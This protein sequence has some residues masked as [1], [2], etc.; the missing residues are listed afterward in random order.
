MLYPFFFFFVLLLCLQHWSA[1][2]QTIHFIHFKCQGVFVSHM[3]SQFAG[4]P[5]KLSPQSCCIIWSAVFPHVTLL[6]DQ[7]RHS[8]YAPRRLLNYS[9][10]PPS[11]H[12]PSVV[13]LGRIRGQLTFTRHIWEWRQVVWLVGWW[14]VVEGRGGCRGLKW[15]EWQM[16]REM[17]KK[18]GRKVL[19]MYVCVCWPAYPSPFVSLCGAVVSAGG[20]HVKSRTL[21]SRMA[22]LPGFSQSE[23]PP[24]PPSLSFTPSSWPA[25]KN[26]Y[27]LC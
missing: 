4:T 6:C 10:A 9:K 26:T 16:K 2:E 15:R 7:D 8:V 3:W 24:T 27:F 1:L 13:V 18:V 14:V 11:L 19:C 12:V 23:P 5:R 17:G 20:G 22:P 21:A 25:A